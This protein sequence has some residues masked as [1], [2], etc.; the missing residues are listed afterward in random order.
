MTS[1]STSIQSP[2]GSD[3]SLLLQT[4]P[5]NIWIHDLPKR[6]RLS[7]PLNPGLVSVAVWYELTKTILH[8][9]S[10]L[11]CES[12]TS[13]YCAVVMGFTTQQRLRKG[14]ATLSPQMLSTKR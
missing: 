7:Q 11:R 1:C 6:R 12:V 8:R 2:T 3:A 14:F 5:C 10:V 13:R 9:V 4:K